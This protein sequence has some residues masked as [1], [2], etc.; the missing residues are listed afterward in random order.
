[1]LMVYTY[2]RD[3]PANTIDL[4]TIPLSELTDSALAI[5]SHQKSADIWLGYLEGW[6]LTPYEE[7]LLRKVLRK[8]QCHVVSHFPLSFSVAWQNEIDTIYTVQ[9]NG[10]SD[11]DH[12]GSSLHDGCEA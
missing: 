6:M 7:V 1:M 3:R 12:D 2:K 8:F 11:S 10:R 4:S 9:V 5:L